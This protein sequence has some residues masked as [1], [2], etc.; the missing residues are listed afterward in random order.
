[1][2]RLFSNLEF[3]V[4][5]ETL[6][7]RPETEF[8]VNACAD[9]VRDKP[10]RILD[11]GT[12]SGNIAVSLTK[13][14][15]NCKIVALDKSE[16]ALRVARSNALYHGVLDRI[17]FIKSD[18]FDDIT[19]YYDIIISN[20]PYVPTWEIETLAEHVRHEPLMA[21]D[22]GEDGLDY[23][24]RILAA[25]PEFLKEGGHLLMEMGYNQV[26]RIRK[27]IG[28]SGNF[29]VVGTIR[30]LLNIERVIISRKL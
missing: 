18:L 7:P 12:G 28:D 6:S 27:L 25:A 26:F 19:G 4:T 10:L 15:G 5:K 21:L 3:E 30:D 16:E 23:Y 2:K 17:D 8:L 22:G 14:C 20:P 24:R 11:A 13:R 1:M 29:K 9:I